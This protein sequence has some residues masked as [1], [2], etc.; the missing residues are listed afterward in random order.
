MMRWFFSFSCLVAVSIAAKAQMPF[1]LHL[2]T[3]AGILRFTDLQDNVYEYN[4]PIIFAELNW[5]ISPY[6]AVGTF[7]SFGLGAD[8][9]TTSF[10]GFNS[11]SL[12][13]SHHLYGLKLRV[14]S[15]RLRLLRPFFEMQYGQF[16]MT[17]NRSN[18]SGSD[19]TDFWATSLGLMIKLSDRLYLVAPQ[20]TMRLR[21]HGFSFEKQSD[22][23]FERP[24][25]PFAE[26]TA[27]I[28]YNLR[29]H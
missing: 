21:E 13:T 27:G 25:S 2:K 4:T 28:S 9:K 19:L 1:D 23:I 24:Y 16:E 14:S 7:Y 29:R 6:F 10:N 20:F 26:V 12:T 17:M 15:G 3:G 5:N 8:T 11:N 18:G 22:H